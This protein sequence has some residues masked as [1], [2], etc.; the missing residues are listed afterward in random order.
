MDPHLITL[1]TGTYYEATP[2]CSL[3]DLTIDPFELNDRRS[4]VMEYDLL[5]TLLQHISLN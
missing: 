5:Q 4:G 1:E 2:L 3:S